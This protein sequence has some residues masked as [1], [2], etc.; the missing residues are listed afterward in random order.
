MTKDK[1]TMTVEEMKANMK[2]YAE[3]EAEYDTENDKDEIEEINKKEA[4]EFLKDKDSEEDEQRPV[5]D[6][7]EEEEPSFTEEELRTMG[8]SE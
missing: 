5:S 1:K 4:E 6:V 3:M 8:T 7:K 2:S